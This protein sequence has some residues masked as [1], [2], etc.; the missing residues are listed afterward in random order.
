MTKKITGKNLYNSCIAITHYVNKNGKHKAG[1]HPPEPKTTPPPS[2]AVPRETPS[3]RKLGDLAEPSQNVKIRL[4]EC[5]S[6]ESEREGDDDCEDSSSS[7]EDDEGFVTLGTDLDSA[8]F[9]ENN[10]EEGGWVLETGEKI[11]NVLC[12]MTSNAI[13]QARKSKKRDSCA[14]STIRLGLS[15]I[16]DLSSEFPGGMHEWFGKHWVT[17][18]A[19]ALEHLK[20]T[21]WQFEDSVK[22]DVQKIIEVCVQ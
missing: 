11:R 21:P 16:I 9:T 20:I 10:D 15:S 13:E 4:F 7:D 18:K 17:L 8:I 12:S 3:K 1:D 19:K 22:S 2:L 6:S 5:Q 14:L